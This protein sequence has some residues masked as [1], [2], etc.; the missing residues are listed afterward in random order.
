[1]SEKIPEVTG[2]FI[3]DDESYVV[4]RKYEYPVLGSIADR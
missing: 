4:S 2:K 3:L 1:M